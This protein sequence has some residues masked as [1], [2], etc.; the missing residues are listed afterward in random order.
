M[1][2]YDEIVNEMMMK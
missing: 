1:L 2:L